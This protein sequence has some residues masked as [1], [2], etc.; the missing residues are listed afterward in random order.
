MTILM[1]TT[2]RHSLRFGLAALSLALAGH[3]AAALP[4]IAA[5][6]DTVVIGMGIEPTGLDPTVAAPA[7]IGQVTW[8]N[9]FQGLTR[10]DQ[11]GKVQPQLAAGW[12]IA[13][14]GRTYL[15]KLREGVRFSNGVPFDATVAKFAL[16]RARG[17]DST[18]PQ[19]QFFSVISDIEVRDPRT[20]VLHLSS[21]AGNLL[22]WLG[23]PSSVMVEP[24]SADAN[25]SQPVGTGP[26]K[27][28][29]WR[30]GDR[31]ELVRNEDY[32]DAENRPALR[33][34]T[35]R[36][37]SDAQAQAAAV[38]S[39]D[40]DA[41]PE[42]G[43]PELF[44][45]FKGDP[46]LTTSVGDTELKVV[47]GLN[48]RKAPFDNP[49]VRQALMMAIDRQTVIE[50]AWSGYGTPIGSHY[51]PND[52]GY[53]DT[54]G[55]YPYD[56]EKAKALLA[57][58]GYPDGLSLT[59]KTPQMSYATRTSEVLQAMLAEIGVQ[60]QIVP[61]E[62]PGKWIS[63]VF[64]GHDF[65]MTIVA[66]AEPLDIGIYARDDYYFGYDNPAFSKAVA[67]AERT[68]DTAARLALYGE[69]QRMLAADVPALYLFVMPKLGVWDAKLKGLWVNE[70]IPSNDLSDVTWDE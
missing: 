59:I 32:W 62:F 41:F 61:T 37:I 52:P 15:F 5:P 27:L 33:T 23:W 12:T 55:V 8:Q 58:A 67:E 38:K 57:E 1:L 46:R 2:A 6:K 45:S 56:P 70:P 60:L 48:G 7:A 39:G 19:K 49:K 28:A 22:Y 42:F 66:H 16:D 30:Q 18:N 25:K 24:S 10:I 35:F 17:D 14:E 68:T 29:S 4:A 9:V 21:P 13:D 65:D 31:L 36:F 50:G 63:E 51:T 11:D 69:A 44:A 53:V 40:V 43:A 3:F 20:L 64:K 26:F 34:A 54:T 47:A